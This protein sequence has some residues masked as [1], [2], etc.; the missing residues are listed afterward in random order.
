MTSS[1]ASSNL[2][3]WRFKNHYIIPRFV[4]SGHVYMCLLNRRIVFKDGDLIT[5]CLKSIYYN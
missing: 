5:K 1:F 2:R 3:L 4:K